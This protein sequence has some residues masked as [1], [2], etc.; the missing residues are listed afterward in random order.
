MTCAGRR[1]GAIF[2][3]S[4]SQNDCIRCGKHMTFHK[5]PIIY[6][7]ALVVI[8]VLCGCSSLSRP[9]D[10]TRH[11]SCAK[12]QN[13]FTADYETSSRQTYVV[14][15]GDSELKMSLSEPKTADT[16]VAFTIANSKST[17]HITIT[18]GLAVGLDADGYLMTAGH[19]VQTNNYVLGWF[20]G[21][22]CLRPARVVFRNKFKK[23]A[24]LALL[25]V[26]GKLDHCAIFGELPKVGDRVF[27]VACYH[28]EGE[29]G[30]DI[31]FTGGKVV[32]V[33]GRAIGKFSGPD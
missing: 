5:T 26:A 20:D 21:K 11:E 33:R 18:R 25:K 17:N 3:D 12:I 31:D 8:A 13:L 32:R 2:V 30:G 9:S 28:K 15:S 7:L 27:A 4:R 10:Q 22:I 16:G 23:H 24:D 1:A 19:V 29:L 14:F 6:F